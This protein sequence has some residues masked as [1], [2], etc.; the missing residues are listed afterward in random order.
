MLIGVWHR[1]VRLSSNLGVYFCWGMW[2]I[3]VFALLIVAQRLD[4]VLMWYV[5]GVGI[6]ASSELGSQLV[7]L[8]VFT[9][10]AGLLW[11]LNVRCFCWKRAD[12]ISR[13]MALPG[14]VS[15][16]TWLFHLID[17][18]ENSS[19]TKASRRL[20]SALII[21]LRSHLSLLSLGLLWNR[22][23]I[24]I[25][26]SEIQW[27]VKKWCHDVL[28]I[29]IQILVAILSIFEPRIIVRCLSFRHIHL[30]KGL[31]RK[32]AF[33]LHIPYV[34][35]L[36]MTALRRQIHTIAT[37]CI[38][39]LIL[40]IGLRLIFEGNLIDLFSGWSLLWNRLSTSS[41]DNWPRM[42]MVNCACTWWL[43]AMEIVGLRRMLH[44]HEILA[45]ILNI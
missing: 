3:L 2:S 36:M 37:T 38:V 42:I 4:T 34:C 31:G 27:L 9:W 24:S 14:D 25:L 10:M 35:L 16:V 18:V 45:L 20:W 11:S 39:I 15:H 30:V 5:A 43:V 32:I 40:L 23:R 7:I 33:A 41:V 19:S 8:F 28:C 6:I 26:C 13:H 12:W 17:F 1:H 29:W 22:F 44:A 21:Q